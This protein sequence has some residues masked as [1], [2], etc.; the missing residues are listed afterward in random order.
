M[1]ARSLVAAMGASLAIIRNDEGLMRLAERANIDTIRSLRRY[2]GHADVAQLA[3][4]LIIMAYQL[5][6]FEVN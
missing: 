6:S 5:I 2:T 4:P 1:L 3:V